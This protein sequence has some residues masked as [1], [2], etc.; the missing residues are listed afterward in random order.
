MDHK[1]Q[2]DLILANTSDWPVEDCITLAFAILR[3]FDSEALASSKCE[4]VMRA[5]A[6]AIE[7]NPPGDPAVKQWIDEYR[8]N[9]Y[10][11]PG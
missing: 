9:K 4:S 5:L 2:I 7:T 6:I 1:A 10:G 11:K 8:M 3:T